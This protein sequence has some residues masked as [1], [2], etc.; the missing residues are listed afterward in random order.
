MKH[1]HLSGAQFPPM[2][3]DRLTKSLPECSWV[4]VKNN[5]NNNNL[6]T[7]QFGAFECS[8]GSTSLERGCLAKA[9]PREGKQVM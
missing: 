4:R 8:Q 6:V 5:N 9:Q 3:A 7:Q 1:I 2:T